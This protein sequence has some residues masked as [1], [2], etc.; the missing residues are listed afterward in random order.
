MSTPR[1][2]DLRAELLRHTDLLAEARMRS[3]IEAIV[4]EGVAVRR[5]IDQIKAVEMV[6]ASI[7]KST[8]IQPEQLN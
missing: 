4:I 7:H 5:L 6:H 3:D 8:A 1:T 2:I